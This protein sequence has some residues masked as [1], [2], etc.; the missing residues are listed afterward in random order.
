M[1]QT[2]VPG[3]PGPETMPI[4]ILVKVVLRMVVVPPDWLSHTFMA[5]VTLGTP[6]E[7]NWKNAASEQLP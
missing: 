1:T 7:E 2:Q 4:P 5:V 3:V 6:P